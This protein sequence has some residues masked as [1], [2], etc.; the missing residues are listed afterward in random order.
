MDR[1][2][3]GNG[4]SK[5]REGENPQRTQDFGLA[6][7]GA[8]CVLSAVHDSG[9][10]CSA[11]F[12]NSGACE[13]KMCIRDR[14]WPVPDMAP[15]PDKMMFQNSCAACLISFPS[16]WVCSAPSLVSAFLHPFIYIHLFTFIYLH[17]FIYIR[18]FIFVYLHLLI[19]ICLFPSACPF[20][21]T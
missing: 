11:G 21:C 7:C 8:V 1:R 12:K 15:A 19:Y 20:F 14:P 17:P 5:K 2:R 16:T 4:A 9:K 10:I 18:L 13:G 3:R 6:G